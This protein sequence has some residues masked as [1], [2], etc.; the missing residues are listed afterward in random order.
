M[1]GSIFELQTL[2][3]GLVQAQRLLDSI[4]YAAVDRGVGFDAERAIG[5]VG[6]ETAKAREYAQSMKTGAFWTDR[7]QGHIRSYMVGDG[8]GR[9]AL[10][11]NSIRFYLDEPEMEICHKPQ[12]L[13]DV[14][15][16]LKAMG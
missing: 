10:A 15:R 12:E 2:I 11:L 13:A 3:E 7:T 14:V 9:V 6:I 4:G 5:L 16:R 8:Y 1:A